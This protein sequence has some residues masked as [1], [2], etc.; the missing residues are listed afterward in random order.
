MKWIAAAIQARRPLNITVAV[1]QRPATILVKIVNRTKDFPLHIHQ[2]RIHVGMS[3]C[4]WFFR[5]APH[6][7]V[8]VAPR[9]RIEY[10]LP[11]VETIIGRR[12]TTEQRPNLNTDDSDPPFESCADLFK[13][14]ARAP[15]R[16][17]WLEI[18]FNEFTQ[19]QFLRGKLQPLFYDITQMRPPGCNR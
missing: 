16:D 18:D 7:T 11:F 13:A 3:H 6:D 9:D 1:G 17:V 8:H 4:T 14:I 15:Q 2:V 19:R 5:L 12:Y 10:H